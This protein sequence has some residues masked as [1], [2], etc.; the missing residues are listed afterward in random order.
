MSTPA[1]RV[2][3]DIG[4]TF[5]DLAAVD[6]RTGERWFAKSSTTPDNPTRGIA[7]CIEKLGKPGADM[8]MFVHGTTLVINAC[9]VTVPSAVGVKPSGPRKRSS[10]EPVAPVY[11]TA[12]RD[13]GAVACAR[14]RALSALRDCDRGA[15]AGR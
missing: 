1:L 4:G 2:A 10:R 8:E 5:T 15:P 3:V 13:L 12:G 7:H 11:R 6:T 9:P 14:R